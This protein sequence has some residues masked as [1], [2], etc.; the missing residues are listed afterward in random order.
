[1]N[2][3]A[4]L[5]F[6]QTPLWLDI[7]ST[8]LSGPKQVDYNI[9]IQI[10]TEKGDFPILKVT[11]MTE[12]CDYVKNIGPET[13][14]RFQM[15]LGDYTY[16]LYP[17]RD[18]IEVTMKMIPQLETGGDDMEAETP[19]IRYRGIL[20]MNKN[21]KVT[22]T[23]AQQLDFQTLQMSNSLVEVVLELQDRNYEVLRMQTVPGCTYADTTPEQL[24]AGVLTGQS[25]KYHIDGQPAIQGFSLVKPDNTQPMKTIMVPTMK[26]AD[27]PTFVQQKLNGVYST[28]IGTF[29]E[30]FAG[31]PSWF[32]YP[33]FNTTRF[34]D[35]VERVVFFVVPPDELNGI[36][37]TFRKSGK[38]LYIAITGGNTYDDDSQI[39]DLNEGVGFRQA[40]ATGIITKPVEMTTNGPVADRARLNREIGNR[41]R[42]DGLYYAPTIA[43]SV[44]PFK[45][46]SQIAQRQVSNV[47]VFWQ[48]SNPK[49]IYP[50]M[51][52]KYVF[53]SG[54]EY[55]E[56]T[57]TVL[58][59]F[60]STDLN[61][62]AAT[63][64]TYRTNTQL[65][66]CLEYFEKTPDQPVED[67]PGTF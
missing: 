59:K 48:N 21:P 65:G 13:F 38:V 29:Y 67:S 50:G 2:D 20:D 9:D 37:R 56:I 11:N 26:I 4:K 54:G 64:S 27:I 49:L 5:P 32:V 17:F 25:Q 28:G 43:P 53:M 66:L 52:C 31:K 46:Y 16:R 51:P 35:D 42:K 22:S 41:E 8:I 10:H 36:N 3:E 1:M 34:A 12:G 14:I 39:G 23:R 44:N 62:A 7:E 30:R 33:L 19:T 60:T 18:T 57:G 6:R 40:D 63:S 58:G 47:N 61:G 15:G 45:N 24:I 55:I